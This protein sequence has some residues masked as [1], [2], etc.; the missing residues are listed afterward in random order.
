MKTG[1]VLEMW[2]R[3]AALDV[4]NHNRVKS[5][6]GANPVIDAVPLERTSGPRSGRDVA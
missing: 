1:S 2:L 3:E 6:C 4:L 5:F